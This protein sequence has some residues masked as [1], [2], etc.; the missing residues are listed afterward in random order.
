MGRIPIPTS[1]LNERR[2]MEVMLK[3]SGLTNLSV[4]QEINRLSESKFWGKISMRTLESD[5]AAH[6]REHKVI[7]LYEHDHIKMM[8]ECHLAQMENTMEELSL[9]I[10][11]KDKNNSW[12]SFEKAA[13]L[14]KLYK[15]RVT[16][17]EMQGWNLSKRQNYKEFVNTSVW[18]NEPELAERAV[19]G[20][21]SVPESV[22]NGLADTLRSLLQMESGV[23]MI[24]PLMARREENEG[25]Y[26]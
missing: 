22:T 19:R 2:K 24:R 1:L 26:Y 12:K 15:M 9:M 25:E 21:Q 10:L 13:A 7:T 4:L 23:Q 6:F 8:R 20:L 14:E 16:Y 18:S 11:E 5:I 17:A 3:T